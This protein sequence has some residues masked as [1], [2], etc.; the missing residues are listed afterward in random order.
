MNTWRLLTVDMLEN[1]T[2]SG[3]NSIDC[4]VVLLVW[5]QV[6]QLFLGGFKASCCMAVLLLQQWHN[7]W[8][9]LQIPEQTLAFV[10]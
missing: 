6:I 4:T 2:S 9:I 3:H 8:H 5:M 7:S 1:I 10:E